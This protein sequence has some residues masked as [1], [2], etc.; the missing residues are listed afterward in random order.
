M[1]AGCSA[2]GARGKAGDG[3]EVLSSQEA[4][5]DRS[6]RVLLELCRLAGLSTGRA[7]QA[8]LLGL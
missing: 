5:E 1:V 4:R 7:C 8:S 3:A 2:A 6:L